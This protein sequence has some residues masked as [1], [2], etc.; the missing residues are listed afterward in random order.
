[1]RGL[2]NSVGTGVVDAY[3]LSPASPAKL[4]NFATRG[5]VQPGDKLM[6]AGFI[7]Q[8]GPV[9]AVVRAIGPS[10][11]PLWYPE[12]LAEYDPSAERPERRDRAG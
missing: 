9:R 2:N 3:D 7:I 10:L 6:I 1:M 11:A 5:L 8:N 4:A 12:R